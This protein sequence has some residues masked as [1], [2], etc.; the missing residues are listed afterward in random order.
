MTSL[1]RAHTEEVHLLASAWPVTGNSHVLLQIL[2]LGSRNDRSGGN[3]TIPPSSVSLPQLYAA[4]VRS[5]RVHPFAVNLFSCSPNGD[6]KIWDMRALKVS[7]LL[8]SHRTSDSITLD[9]CSLL[10][11]ICSFLGLIMFLTRQNTLS[12]SGVGDGITSMAVHPHLPILAIGSM[13]QVSVLSFASFSE[14]DGTCLNSFRSFACIQ[15]RQ[16]R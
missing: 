10:K 2:S 11:E 7:S 9:V 6:L 12:V 4:I 5:S 14:A 1:H 13:G 15:P 8:L 16:A 3:G